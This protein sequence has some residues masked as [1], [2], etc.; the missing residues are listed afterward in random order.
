MAAGELDNIEQML[1]HKRQ[2]C[3]TRRQKKNSR[4]FRRTLNQIQAVRPGGISPAV[5]GEKLF[6]EKMRQ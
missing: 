6:R 1:R 3:V 5:H 4:P 2:S